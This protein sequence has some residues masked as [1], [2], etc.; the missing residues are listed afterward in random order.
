MF[1]F[2]GTRRRV[3]VVSAVLACTAAPAVATAQGPPYEPKSPAAARALAEIG[4][5]GDLIDRAEAHVRAA[6][7][8]CRGEVPVRESRVTHDVP[9]ADVL[10]AIAALRR[11]QAA[12][13]R[14]PEGRSLLG[15]GDEVYVDHTRTVTAP[16][17][18]QF[19][20][21]LARATPPAPRPASCADA[22]HARLLRTTAK[23][24]GRVRSRTLK[25]H[26]AS[27]RQERRRAERPRRPYDGVYLFDRA[28]NGTLGSGG[29]GGG[30]RYFL[31]HGNVMS[32]GSGGS[33]RLTGLVPDGVASVEMTFPKRVSRGRYYK[34][35]VFPRREVVEA[36]V[37]EGVF[38]VRVPRGAGDAFASRTV[39]RGADGRVIRVVRR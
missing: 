20:I 22:V 9:G 18:R 25:Q 6:R 7:K 8:V 11:P 27:R 4:Q 3:L 28:A 33:S 24:S 35:T 17:G 13:D 1:P 26:A 36:P 21:V 10:G 5:A 39:W 23:T 29:G 19:V 37:Q 32:S 30:F 15:L 34:P 14:I 38:S 2:P 16:D 12:T 31:T